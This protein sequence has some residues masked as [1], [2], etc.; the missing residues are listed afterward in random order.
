[1][2]LIGLLLLPLRA[3]PSLSNCIDDLTALELARA[4]SSNAESTDCSD[5]LAGSPDIE[6][7]D[8]NELVDCCSGCSVCVAR[9]RG[10][11]RGRGEVETDD[12]AK[13]LIIGLRLFPLLLLD[14]LPPAEVA[15]GLMGVPGTSISESEDSD[16]RALLL[17]LS[18]SNPSVTITLRSTASAASVKSRPKRVSVALAS[19][20]RSA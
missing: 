18:P 8:D 16:A 10:G 11:L 1:M 5:G 4:A 3:L 20:R 7:D 2:S 6:D 12:T 17:T 14:C 13:G 19:S 15:N 9:G